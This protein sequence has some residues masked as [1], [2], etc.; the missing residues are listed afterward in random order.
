MVSDYFVEPKSRKE[1]RVLAYIL[2]EK[3]GLQ[4]A[5]WIP[6][7]ELLDVLAETIDGFSYEVVPDSE[8]PDEIHAETDIVTG[9][10]TI[11][12]SVYERACNGEG[13]DRMTIAHEIGHFF[14][15]YLYGFKLHRNYKNR[16]IEAPNDPEWQAKCFAGEFLIGSHLIEGM[17]TFEIAEEC[18]VSYEAAKYQLTHKDK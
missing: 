9:H 11:K 2:R 3:L 17:S 1:I 8:M 7:V 5:L 15:L 18:G 4:N 12:E 14:M 10:I 6:V 13:R 16:K